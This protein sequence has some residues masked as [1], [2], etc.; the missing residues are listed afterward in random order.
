[1]DKADIDLRNVTYG[2]L[3]ILGRALIAGEVA[4]AARMGQGG[5]RGCGIEFDGGALVR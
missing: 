3:R 2:Q 1:M 5:R 4:R